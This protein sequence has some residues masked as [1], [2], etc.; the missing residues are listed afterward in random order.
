MFVE[1]FDYEYEYIINCFRRLLP[2]Y[3]LQIEKT[4]TVDTCLKQLGLSKKNIYSFDLS[5]ENE[6]IDKVIKLRKQL[7]KRKNLE[8]FEL[9]D[10]YADFFYFIEN[11]RKRIK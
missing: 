7:E 5:L 4:L 1:L 6:D 2:K 9:Y 10:D 8:D 3:C 11:Y